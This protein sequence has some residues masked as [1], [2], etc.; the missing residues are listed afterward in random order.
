MGLFGDL[1]GK[2]KKVL[3]RSLEDDSADHGNTM[4]NRQTQHAGE[5]NDEPGDRQKDHNQEKKKNRL[6]LR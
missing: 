4:K 5:T 3:P 1:G 6:L 2:R